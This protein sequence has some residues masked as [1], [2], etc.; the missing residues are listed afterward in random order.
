MLQLT[1]KTLQESEESECG[2]GWTLFA[3]PMYGGTTR[4]CLSAEIASSCIRQRDMFYYPEN[5]CPQYQQDN[6]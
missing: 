3:L 6:Y 4:A 1:V 2:A 5:K